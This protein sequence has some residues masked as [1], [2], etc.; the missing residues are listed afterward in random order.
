MVA[1]RALLSALISTLLFAFAF[2]GACQAADF[3]IYT[4]EFPR[5]AEQQGGMAG[6]MYVEVMRK[7]AQ[8]TGHH[9]TWVFQPWPRAQRSAQ[10]DPKG[11]IVNLTRNAGREAQYSWVGVIGWGR[12][13]IFS[14]RQSAGAACAPLVPSAQMIGYLNGSDVLGALQVE[15]FANL[16]GAVTSAVNARKLQMARIKGWAV[17]VWTGPSMYEQAGFSAASLCVQPLGPN[18][19]QWLA[20]SLNFPAEAAAQ[21]GASLRKLRADGSFKSLENQYWRPVPGITPP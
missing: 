5:L 2:A 17:N 13:G 4:T 15:G 11:L 10:D 16:E 12:Y 9:F 14:L 8:A 7:V 20:A 6:G 19:D 1:V 21:I 18:W 3:T